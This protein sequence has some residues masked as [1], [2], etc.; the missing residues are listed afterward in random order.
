MRGHKLIDAIVAL[1]R[2]V[3]AL[4]AGRLTL[5]WYLIP[6]L[7]AASWIVFGLHHDRARSTV[8]GVVA[9]AALVV[10]AL[11][12]I[13]FRGFVGAARLGTGPKLALL[14]G[15]LLCGAAWLPRIARKPVPQPS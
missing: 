4:S 12:Y 2:H 1:G 13:A 11:A 7:G 3:P 8:A 10:T 15:V 9:L 6:A 14:G 5:L